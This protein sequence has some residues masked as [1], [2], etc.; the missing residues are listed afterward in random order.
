MPEV[1]RHARRRSRFHTRLRDE[2]QR[3][4]ASAR[5]RAHDGNAA[6]RRAAASDADWRRE[7][8]LDNDVPRGTSAAPD[9]RGA[10][11]P[12]PL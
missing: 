10:L 1:F 3:A 12:P 5:R 4:R 2:A 8:R 7:Q 9:S 6:A 11:P